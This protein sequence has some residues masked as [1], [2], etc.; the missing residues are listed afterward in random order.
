M[1]YRSSKFS[2]VEKKEIVLKGPDGHNSSQIAILVKLEPKLAADIPRQKKQNL[3]G[4]TEP[5]SE[6]F[7]PKH[8]KTEQ[9]P[10]FC[11][12]VAHLKAK[13]GHDEYRLAQGKHLQLE[14]ASFAQGLPAVICGDF[15]AQPAESVYQYFSSKGDLKLASAYATALGG[16]EPPSLPGSSDLPK[17]A[18]MLLITFGTLMRHCT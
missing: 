3:D 16:K 6:T 2:L 9:Q 12:A 10:T 5:E 13:A 18:N 15:N 1:F 7:S 11:V 4:E 17:R 8:K 14:L